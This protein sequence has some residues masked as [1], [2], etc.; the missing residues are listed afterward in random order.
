MR[1]SDIPDLV[2]QKYEIYPTGNASRP[3]FLCGTPRTVSVPSGS[4]HGDQGTPLV[5]P[6]PPPPPRQR[7]AMATSRGLRREPCAK[8]RGAA[9]APPHVPPGKCLEPEAA[10]AMTRTVPGPLP[11]PQSRGGAETVSRL[12]HA[13]YYIRSEKQKRSFVQKK[14]RCALRERQIALPLQSKTETNAAWRGR[15]VRETKIGRLAQLVQSVC[16][17]SRGSA[18]RIRQRPQ[19]TMEWLLSSTE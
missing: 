15:S 8:G 16:L 9:Q 7:E 18:V 10:C 19:K 12:A 2:L 1:P 4:C 17:T 3:V 6:S 5:S 11:S 14:V 13:Y